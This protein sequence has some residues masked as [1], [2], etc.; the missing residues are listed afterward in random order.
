MENANKLKD[1]TARGLVWGGVSNVTQQLLNLVFGVWVSRILEVEDYGTIGMLTIFTLIATTL[2]ESGFT[3]AITNKK[4]TSH[5]DFNSVFWFSS[6]IGIFLYIILFFCAPY[7]ADFF[8]TPD[9]TTL[10]RVLFLGFLFSS[11][12]TAHNAY[13]FKHMMVKERAIS[14]ISG[15]LLAGIVGVIL[16]TKGYAYWGLAYQHL[17]YIICTNLLFW[18]FSKWRPTLQFSFQPIKQMFS[19]SYKILITKICI[20]LNNHVFN[21]ILGKLFNEKYVGYFTQANKWNLMGS[22]VI[23]E[24]IQGVAQ[25]LFKNVDEDIELKQQLFLKMLRFTAFVAFPCLLGLAFIAPEFIAILLTE[26]WLFSANLLSILCIGGAFLPLNNL[27]SN[28]IIS[29]GKSNI[30]MW[31]SIALVAVQL[32]SALL[33]YPYGI[34]VMI[35]SFVL[36]QII[37]F[38]I[39]YVFVHNV[40]RISLSKLLIQVVPYALITT[41]CIAI[42]ALLLRDIENIYLLLVFKVILVAVLY[43]TILFFGKFSILTETI[44]QL[45]RIVFKRQLK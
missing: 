35:S 16:A 45:K 11:L 44:Y 26:K 22:S 7:I 36:L 27:M 40:V 4:E 2:Q 18:Y 13:L 23:T 42:T 32:A 30:F 21:I 12:G 1:K 25:P 14:M 24:M 19:F 17:T 8:H 33:L 10:A 28:L 15:L 34:K 29:T 43:I 39:W 20:H 3:Q 41:F 9:L 38:F 5:R 37:W 31:N 6:F